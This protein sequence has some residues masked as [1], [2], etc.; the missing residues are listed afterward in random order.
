MNNMY[1]I[2]WMMPIIYIL[3]DFEEISLAEVWAKR[4]K[5]EIDLAWPKRQPFGINYVNHYQT[6]TFALGVYVLFLTSS[7]VTLLSV[8]FQNYFLWYGAFLGITLHLI[9]VHM[10]LCIKFK[11][12]VPGVITSII[13]L[14]PSIWFLYQSEMILH[15]G[16]ITILLAC[17]LGIALTVFFMLFIHKQMGHWSELL[18]KYSMGREQ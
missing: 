3:H 17:L 6:P 10:L 5:K 12:Y 15:Y 16:V 7:V 2:V 1:F 4:F 11:H 9:F 13:L 14:I 8:V 18:Y